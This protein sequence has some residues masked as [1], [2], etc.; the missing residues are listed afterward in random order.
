MTFMNL[1]LLTESSYYLAEATYNNTNLPRAGLEL[2]T[3]EPEACMLAIEPP[4][5]DVKSHNHNMNNEG[6]FPKRLALAY[7]KKS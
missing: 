4:L 6:I 7:E 2:E 5:P 3:L 1:T